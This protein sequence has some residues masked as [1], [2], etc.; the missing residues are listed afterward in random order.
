M[1]RTATFDEAA[2][3]HAMVEMSRDVTA[4]DISIYMI[5][6]DAWVMAI[7]GRL[8]SMATDGV[9]EKTGTARG[10]GSGGYWRL[11]EVEA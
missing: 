6:N 7:A 9:V 8:K 1:R 10:A 5:G 11:K 2:I 3:L 4:A